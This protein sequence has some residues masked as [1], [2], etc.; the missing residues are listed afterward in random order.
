MSHR[1]ILGVFPNDGLWGEAEYSAAG[2]G[3]VVE[4]LVFGFWPFLDFLLV[5]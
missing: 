4:V 2:M 1:E 5:Y 3:K